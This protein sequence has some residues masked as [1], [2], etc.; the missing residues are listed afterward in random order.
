MKKILGIVVLCLICNTVT[1][2]SKYVG[3][4]ELQLK[5]YYVKYF[6]KYL[7]PPAGQ[8][9]MIFYVMS[10]NGKAIWSTYW[11]C[12]FGNCQ[13]HDMSRAVNLCK[14]DAE[15]HYKRTINA[16]CKIFA[17]KRIIVWDNQINPGKGKASRINSKWSD[18][19]I[20]AKLT[21]LGFLGGST[22]SSSNKSTTP[23]IIKKVKKSTNTDKGDIVSQ[24]K[25]LKDLLDAGAITQD[26]FVKAKKKIL[27]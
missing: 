25:G 7:K 11:Y 5:N 19:E 14:I 20:K 17:K 1:A 12:P 9:P 3:I 27:N 4:G 18:A 6:K 8:S 22:T 13:T 16:E 10:E 26:E 15:K 21:E 23:K 24:I 2:A